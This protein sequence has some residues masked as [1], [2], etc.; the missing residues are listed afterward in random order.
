M[1]SNLGAEIIRDNYEDLKPGSESQVFRK[2]REEVFDLLRHTLRPEFLN[3]VDEII[4]FKPLLPEEIKEVVK[5]QLIQL[6]QMLGTQ[7]IQLE[8]T[9]YA[10]NELANEGY[11]PQLGARPIKRLIQRKIINELSKQLLAGKINKDQSVQLD[12]MDGKYVF[13]SMP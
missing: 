6:I 9:E 10:L 4:M 13:L 3:R 8:Y 7:G 2:T 1:T 12:V 11:D 5:L